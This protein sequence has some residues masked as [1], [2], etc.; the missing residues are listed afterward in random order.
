MTGQGGPEDP[1]MWDRMAAWWDRKQGE[2]GSRPGECDLWG[3]RAEV[4]RRAGQRTKTGCPY[5]GSC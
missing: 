5:R 4:M 2:E 3:T 1:E